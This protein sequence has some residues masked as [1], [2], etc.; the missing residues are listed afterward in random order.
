[1]KTEI[2]GKRNRTQLLAALAMTVAMICAWSSGASADNEEQKL[3]SPPIM[4]NG[5]KSY[6]VVMENLPLTAYE[7]DIQGLP[8]TKPAKGKKFNPNSQAAK[9]YKAH[10]EA[11]QEKALSSAGV[12]KNNRTNSFTAA[13]NGFSA[14]LTESQRDQLARTKGVKKVIEDQ[15]RQ[16]DTDSSPAFLGLTEPAS[17]WQTGITGEGVIVGIIDSG[18]WPEH[19]SFADDGSLPDAPVLDNSR[20]NCEFG[21]T[22]HNPNDVPFSCNNKLIG[23][24]QMIDT[25]RAIVGADPEEFDSARDDDGHGTH[26]A[27][28]AAGNA[29][30]AASVSGIPRGVVSG[31]APRA[32]IIAYKGLGTLGGFTSDLASAIDQAVADGVDVIN[33]SIGGGASGPGGDEIAFL[34]AEAAGVFV[35]T[36]AGNSGPGPATLGNPGTMPW[37]TT[38]GASTQPRFFQGTVVLD[39]GSEYAGASLTQGLAATALVDAEFAGGDLCLPGTLDPI[40]VTG[41]VVL[42]RRGAIARADKSLAVYQAGGVGTILYNN[43][44]DDN[45]SPDNHS[46]PAVHIDNT[47]GLAIKAHIAAGGS[48]TAAIIGE[49]VGEWESAPSMAIFSSRGP[50]PI[51]PDILKPDIT[52]PGFQV[53]A[54]NTPFPIGGVQGELFQAIG[55]T[56]MSSPHVAGAFALLKQAHPDWTPAM[57]KSA[58]MTTS[59]QNVV[60][61][62]RSSPADPFGMGSGHMDLGEKAQKGSVFQPGLAYDAG[63]FEYAAFSCG[64]NWDIFTPGSCTFLDSIGVPSEAYNLNYPSIGLADIPGSRTVTR[65]V[66]SVANDKGWRTY[67]VSVSKPPGYDVTVSPSSFRLKPGQSASYEVTV[68]NL[69]AP[70]GEW[71]F[72]SLTWSDTTGHYDV[73]SP[74]VVSGAL[75]SGPAAVTGSGE[76]GSTSFGVAFGYTGDYT[77]FPIGLL[78]ATVTN[79]NVV[80]DPDQSFDPDDGFSNAHAITVAPGTTVLRIAMPPDAVD[81]PAVDLDLFLFDPSGTQA[82]A[83]TSGGTDEFLEITFP[84]PGEWT[85]Y[86]HGWQTAGPSAD[87][88]MYQW[89]LPNATGGSLVVDSAPASAEVGKS[90]TVDVSWSGATVG[91]WYLGVIGHLGASGTVMGGTFVEVDNR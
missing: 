35:A 17:V 37:M 78:A 31:I 2:E 62:D 68:T 85:V 65:T 15:W 43:S 7:G 60:D 59:Y 84:S 47:P 74:I 44:D 39:N 9:K 21:N 75:F 49:Q 13:L 72:G 58:L 61:N 16:L 12:S 64:Q 6:I 86:V 87:Y 51:T 79:D 18:I 81:D 33:Y 83:S 38:V 63:L 90:G 71:R 1:M 29:G 91:E 32:H 28:T 76:S 80:Q 70:A 30:V 56:S 34:F 69:G 46:T 77:A 57:A 14:I 66:T 82:Q 50:N 23:A 41:K 26:T 55:G 36:S 42:C 27:S 10:L 3:S 53:L 89:V 52:G 24:R 5:A 48:P 54:G 67:N 88:L 45:L 11:S 8:A 40:V 19:P 22:A 4:A 25:Y 73:Y 20:P